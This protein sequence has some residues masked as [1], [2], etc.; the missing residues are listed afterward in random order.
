[1]FFN[2]ELHFVHC[3]DKDIKLWFI[4]KSYGYNDKTLDQ[5]Q[6]FDVI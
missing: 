5:Y 6:I 1:M 2:T 3:H 4:F